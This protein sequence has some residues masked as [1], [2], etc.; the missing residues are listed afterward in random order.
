LIATRC[1]ELVVHGKSVL[2]PMTG[3]SASDNGAVALDL[4]SFDRYVPAGKPVL[5]ATG[6]PAGT[7]RRD[8]DVDDF[9]DQGSLLCQAIPLAPRATA[10]TADSKLTLCV[11]AK[12]VKRDAS[13]GQID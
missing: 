12:D 8:L 9:A 13:K 10:N 3:S 4:V 1:A 2:P 11:R 7:T 5:F 6:K